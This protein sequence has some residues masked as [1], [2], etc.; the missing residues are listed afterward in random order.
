MHFSHAVVSLGENSCWPSVR[1][2]SDIQPIRGEVPADGVRWPGVLHGGG[3]QHGRGCG[4]YSQV[5]Q[6]PHGRDRHRKWYVAKC[7]CVIFLFFFL[8]N[9]KKIDVIK[10]WSH[11][12]GHILPHR[13]QPWSVHASCKCP[14]SYQALL[15]TLLTPFPRP[16][17]L[18]PQWLMSS[19]TLLSG[20]VHSL[21]VRLQ[22]RGQSPFK[23]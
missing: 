11:Y 18:L 1:L 15:L 22:C 7:I 10:R 2:L 21:P 4:T 5:W 23:M 13:G 17:H 3:G 19:D 9:V 14:Y 12:F 16:S 8:L 20:W 6:L